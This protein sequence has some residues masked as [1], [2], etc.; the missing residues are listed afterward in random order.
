M[1]IWK[2]ASGIKERLADWV[3]SDERR[4]GKR[5]LG[6]DDHPIRPEHFD[7]SATMTLRRLHRAGHQAYL[8][9]GCIR[10]LLL[11]LVPKDFDVVTDASPEQV[12]KIF[13]NSRIIGRRFRLVHLYFGRDRVIEVSTFRAPSQPEEAGDLL[14]RRDN[15]FGS[16]VEDARRRD[17]RVN[18]L[19]YD[20]RHEAILDYVGGVRDIERRVLRMIG[21]PDVRLREDPV[22]MLRAV[23]L[24]AKTG[25]EIDPRLRRAITRHRDE[26]TRCAPARLQ[27]ETMRLLR[28]GYATQTVA[29][30]RAL[31][32]LD[33]VLPVLSPLL[34]D[35]GGHA[36]GAAM[37][38]R[39]LASLDVACQNE[40][41]GDA[42]VFAAVMGPAL[43]RA[44]FSHPERRERNARCQ[45]L[46]DQYDDALPLTRRLKD[47][48]RH[49]ILTQSHLEPGAEGSGRGRRRRGPAP[50]TLLS[51]PS[52]PNALAFLE[53]RSRID[54]SLAPAVARWQEKWKDSRSDEDGDDPADRPP[55]RRRRRRRKPR[56]Q[57]SN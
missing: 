54:P 39:Y 34:E 55:P 24:S 9:G 43:E 38:D 7:Q 5:V 17:F 16:E 46:L 12:R 41:V 13:R 27:E 10:D 49:V 29:T 26:I 42:V 19:F 25:L 32:L 52:F 2:A 57:A 22:R 21:A 1:A 11:G 51:R 56:A 50:S 37:L 40:T 23:R 36:K 18:G 33:L 31:K 6:K 15:T 20:L 35:G 3:R 28:I 14:I 45:A 8:V 30:M 44:V 48:L 47:E 53:I 4:D